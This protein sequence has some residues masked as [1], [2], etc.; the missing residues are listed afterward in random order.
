MS[1]DYA[2]I[3][4]AIIIDAPIA[5]VFSGVSD[6]DQLTHWFVK[7]ILSTSIH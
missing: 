1:D 4:R 5:N 7:F 6:Q 3:N 2:V